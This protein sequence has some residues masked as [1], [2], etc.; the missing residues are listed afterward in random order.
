[1]GDL[2]PP[3]KP[4]KTLSLLD[5]FAISMLMLGGLNAGTIGLFNADII[6]ITLG[7]LSLLSRAVYLVILQSAIYMMAMLSFLRK[8]HTTL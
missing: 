7:P 8:Q 2:F 5:R 6:A 3:Q 1:M 4:M